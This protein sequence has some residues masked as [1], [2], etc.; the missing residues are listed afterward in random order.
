MILFVFT[1][2]GSQGNIY[3]NYGIYII[4]NIYIIY[5]IYIYNYAAEHTD[6]IGFGILK[7]LS[8]M[9][10]GNQKV[11][12]CSYISS[13]IVMYSTRVNNTASYI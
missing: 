5:V 2:W 6:T 13:G 10:K 12:T 3:N 4:I 9:G 1:G 8:K 11:L 7:E